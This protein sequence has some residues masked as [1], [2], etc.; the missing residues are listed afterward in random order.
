MTS[1]YAVAVHILSLSH[2]RPDNAG[3][4]KAIA[5]SVGTNAVVRNVIGVLRRAGLLRTRRGVAGAQLTRA[6][7]DVS[8]LG[9]CRRGPRIGV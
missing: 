8:L 4:S 1:Q 9:V 5:G 6:P 7:G 2:L 3:S